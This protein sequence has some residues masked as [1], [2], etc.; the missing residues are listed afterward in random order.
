MASEDRMNMKHAIQH[1]R[2][3]AVNFGGIEGPG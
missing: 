3:E 1:S 2:A